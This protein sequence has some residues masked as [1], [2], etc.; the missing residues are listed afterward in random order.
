VKKCFRNNI[1]EQSVSETTLKNT[2]HPCMVENT[3]FA[4]LEN[5]VSMDIQ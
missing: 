3:N 1:K 5:I 2:L 4:S